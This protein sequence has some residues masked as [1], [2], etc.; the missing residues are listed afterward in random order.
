MFKSPIKE[1]EL[2]DGGK[3]QQNNRLEIKDTIYNK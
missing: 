3:T 2:D 1:V